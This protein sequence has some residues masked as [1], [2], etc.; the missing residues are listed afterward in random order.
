MRYMF[1]GNKDL[2]YEKYCIFE[3]SFKKKFEGYY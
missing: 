1:V 2:T 3:A